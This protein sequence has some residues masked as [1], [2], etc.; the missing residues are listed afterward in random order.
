MVSATPLPTSAP[1]CSA[2][3]VHVDPASVMSDQITQDD[4][5]VLGIRN[6]S[7]RPCLLA[8]APDVQLT[9]GGMPAYRVPSTHRL[10]YDGAVTADMAP[11]QE[12]EVLITSPRACADNGN[13]AG[14]APRYDHVLFTM[15]G[16]GTVV[17]DA[18]L[19]AA[20]G[21]STSD[22]FV[23][24]PAPAPS[25]DP[26]YS[27]TASI[28]L[29]ATATAGERM[30]YVVT[31]RN[32]SD[33]DLELVPVCP[34][35][36]ESARAGVPMKEIYGLNCA[37]A[38]ALPAHGRLRFQMRLHVSEQAEPGPMTVYWTLLTV[39]GTAH[40]TGTVIVTAP[41]HP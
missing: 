27:I 17:V 21:T 36:V 41:N 30:D 25:A 2:A 23:N 6:S 8:D 4:G 16:G 12:T 19:H 9:G 13:G 38:G 22:Y 14:T 11:G 1:A 28:T 31:L 3:Q 20:C 29:P 5:V 35:Y 37:G 34:G 33:S 40:A 7:S 24:P 15:P 32:P 10:P 39:G 18:R 26:W